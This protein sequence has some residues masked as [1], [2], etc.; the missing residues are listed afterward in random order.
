MWHCEAC[1]ICEMFFTG[2]LLLYI[3]KERKGKISKK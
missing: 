3:N 2:H 1:V